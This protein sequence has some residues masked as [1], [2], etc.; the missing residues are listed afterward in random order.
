MHKIEIAT[1]NVWM[2]NK[3]TTICATTTDGKEK[4]VEAHTTFTETTDTL[5]ETFYPELLEKERLPFG[6]PIP[7]ILPDHTNQLAAEI[8]IDRLEK[9]PTTPRWKQG[10]IRFVFRPDPISTNRI[11]IQFYSHPLS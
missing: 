6:V 11:M 3:K 9:K 4:T 1:I 2:S 5:R 8:K 10:R 7:S